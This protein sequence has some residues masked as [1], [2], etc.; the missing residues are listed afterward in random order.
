MRPFIATLL[1]TESDCFSQGI[2]ENSLKDCDDVD[3]LEEVGQPAET[4]ND[5]EDLLIGGTIAD[6]TFKELLNSTLRS[7]ERDSDVNSQ[8]FPED[9][10]LTTTYV[11]SEFHQDLNDQDDGRDELPET[12]DTNESSTQDDYV[13]I[14]SYPRHKTPHYMLAPP[15]RFLLA[16]CCS[17]PLQ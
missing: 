7:V 10:A 15:S 1:T 6:E 4:G 2:E 5:R 13:K 9:P 12:E 3:L 14:L 11:T 16:C 8:G 17:L